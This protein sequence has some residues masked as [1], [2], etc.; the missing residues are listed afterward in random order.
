VQPGIEGRPARSLPALRATASGGITHEVSRVRWWVW[1]L[2]L[3]APPL[4]VA[5][6]RRRDRK[7]AVAATAA[8]RPFRVA[9]LEREFLR[10][11]DAHVPDAA[12]RN[13]SALSQALRAAGVE[14]A[15]ADH[16][17]RLRDRLR[18]ARYGPGGVGDAVELAAELQQVL[19]VI[20]GEPW[21]RRHA[22]GPAPAILVAL[23]LV[24][25]IAA[26]QAHDAEGLYRAGALRAAADSFAA[27]AA[28]ASWDASHWYNLGATLYRAG[29]DGKA[30]A[31][32]T[33]A[34][35]LAP[36]DAVIRQGRSL[37]P[38]PD[39][40][41]AQ[42]LFV[43]PATPAEW[44]VLAA[45]AWLALWIAA[46]RRKRLAVLGAALLTVVM[47]GLGTA[48][49]RRRARPV[50][51]VVVADASV[52]SAPHSAAGSTSHVA[53]GAAVLVGRRYG[54]WLEVRRPDGL[55]GWLRDVEVVP[56]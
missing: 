39:L 8:A 56:L 45:V 5:I 15:V 30:I 21:R 48:E 38:P 50:A 7:H 46:W 1:V 26:A 14:G 55:A 52:R 51:V 20:G 3:L 13:G 35:R 11:L 33:R 44:A 9:G 2:A 34:A 19:R 41:S 43:G 36:R 53:A 27:R 49:W 12:T 42:L 10:T 28:V 54:R 24:G 4:A 47:V 40:A 31:A 32:W 22:R 6:V 37:L 25:R 23:V 16:V 18:T 29:A 17:V